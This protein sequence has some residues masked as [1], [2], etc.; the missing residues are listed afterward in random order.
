MR[1]IN[2]A[3]EREN[4]EQK[5]LALSQKILKET[6]QVPDETEEFEQNEQTE[7][8]RNKPISTEPE[9]MSGLGVNNEAIKNSSR[10]FTRHQKHR[11]Q[12][13]YPNSD[14]K[15]KPE[16][17]KVA[18]SRDYKQGKYFRT[19]RVSSHNTFKPHKRHR[20]AKPVYHEHDVKELKIVDYFNGMNRLNRYITKTKERLRTANKGIIR[21]QKL[22]Q[23]M[24]SPFKKTLINVNEI[25]NF[26]QNKKHE[27][28]EVN[29]SADNEAMV[30][31]HHEELDEKAKWA[32]IMDYMRKN[33]KVLVDALP[34][35]DSLNHT[36]YPVYAGSMEQEN[37]NV[38]Y[39]QEMPVHPKSH[40]D[41]LNI[42]GTLYLQS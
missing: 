19:E 22:H 12:R 31:S 5:Y 15:S 7:A 8:Y 33:P 11:V 4:S 9:S 14:N 34:E 18:K 35:P 24:M 26:V 41:S 6:S 29:Q 32:Q 36:F 23:K 37:A 25:F 21:S 30:I 28:H 16:S 10:G 2:R 40:P 39:S 1:L 13:F 3:R 17:N 27:G 20:Q 38:N 42:V